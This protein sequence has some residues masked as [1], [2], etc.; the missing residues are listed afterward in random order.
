MCGIQELQTYEAN[1][2]RKFFFAFFIFFSFRVSGLCAFSS[3]SR[4]EQRI[5]V[6]EKVPKLALK[7]KK[8]LNGIER[9]ILNKNQWTEKKKR[10]WKWKKKGKWKKKKYAK[11]NKRGVNSF[12]G[13]KYSENKTK[14]KKVQKV[15]V[16]IIELTE[17]NSGKGKKKKSECEEIHGGR[18]TSQ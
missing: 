10:T 15:C 6:E 5:T 1:N 18:K 13:E 7:K 12:N 14:K 16:L 9:K 3:H 11:K 4:K 17:K 8:D 2:W